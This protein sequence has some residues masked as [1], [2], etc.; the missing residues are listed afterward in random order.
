MP[1]NGKSRNVKETIK[2]VALVVLFLLTILLLYVYWKD[3]NPKSFNFDN[4]KN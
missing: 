3:I 4:L 1:D 2:S